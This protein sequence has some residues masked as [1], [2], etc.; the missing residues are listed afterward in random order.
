L[1][2]GKLGIWRQLSIYFKQYFCSYDDY[3]DAK[4]IALRWFLIGKQRFENE[5]NLEKVLKSLRNVKILTLNDKNRKAT[6]A[7]ENENVIEIDS[8]N[9]RREREVRVIKNTL[10][11]GIEERLSQKLLSL[12]TP[13]K[14][15]KTN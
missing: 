5:I 11:A 7:L 9:I 3:I 12:K 15:V 2:I 14:S 1:Q 4:D 10:I 6:L 13:I 8:D